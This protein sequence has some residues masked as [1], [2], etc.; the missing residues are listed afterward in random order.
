MIV[1]DDKEKIF[2]L[3]TKNST[4][5]FAWFKDNFLIHLYWGKRIERFGK[6]ENILPFCGR[7]FSTASYGFER[8]YSNDTL[9]ME[10]PVYGNVDL[11]TPAFHAEYEDGSCIT[12][13]KYI[14][15]KIYE[16]KKPLQ[17]LPATYVEGEG[18][19]D[20]LEV[21]LED[22]LTKMRVI[23][24]YTA[25]NELDVITRSV[26]IQ[27]NGTKNIKLLKVMSAGFDIQGCDYDMLHL[28][29]AWGKERKRNLMI[30]C[31]CGAKGKKTIS[32]RKGK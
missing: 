26:K 23:L 30:S 6:L 4:Y 13:L 22:E 28:W 21:V 25:Y 24:Q 1:F 17:N 31:V 27:N 5:A 29:G 18:E 32:S 12:E 19:A 7:A 15:H 14:S 9:P 16:G 10:F 2:M 3:H 8:K 11:R 20:T